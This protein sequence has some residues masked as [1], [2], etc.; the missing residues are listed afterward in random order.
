M[1]HSRLT[2]P[3]LLRRLLEVVRSV[4]SELDV[5]AVL[6]RVVEEAIEITRARYGAL[7]VV[8]ERRDGLARFITRGIGEDTRRTIG[9]LPHGRGVLGVLISEPKALRLPDVG[10]HPRS[11][12]FPPGHPAMHTFLGVPITVRG[13]AYGNLYL[14]EKEGGEEFSET[15]EE[16]VQVL[17]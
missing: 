17:A 9:E 14:T 2:D 11:Y 13:E 6:G 5:D 4:V 16:A 8:N 15:D 7:G 12:G 3:A 10:S 1:E